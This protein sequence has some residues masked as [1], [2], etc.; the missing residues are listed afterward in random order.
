MIDFIICKIESGYYAFKLE[1]IQRIIEAKELTHVSDSSIYIDGIMTYEKKPIEIINLRRVL[2]F[3]DYEVEIKELFSFLKKEHNKWVDELQDSIENSTPFTQTVNP[4]H[5]EFGK[6]ID[7]YISYDLSIKKILDEI[8]INHTNLHTSAVEIL[9]IAKKSKEE[10]KAL[11]K[12]TLL[13]RDKILTSMDKLL[14]QNSSITL[15]MKKI[16]IYKRDEKIVGLIVDA[17]ENIVH[18]NE[19]ETEFL[20]AETKTNSLITMSEV[21]DIDKKLI[22]IINSINIDAIKEIK[23]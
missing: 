16:L 8:K 20:K 3:V 22:C 21:V 5:C 7:K 18:L 10:A 14:E 12:N 17:I 6:W 13:L 9:K 4:H 23:E 11:F 1:N 2:G 15:S 19:D